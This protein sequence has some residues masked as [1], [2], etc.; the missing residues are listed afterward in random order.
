MYWTHFCKNADGMHIFTDITYYFLQVLSGDT[1]V[2]K[3]ITKG[4]RP[5][6]KTFSMSSLIAP[7]L[8]KRPQAS[9]P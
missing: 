2:I 1:V 7:K 9:G 6:E 4:R 8:A 5:A 3:A